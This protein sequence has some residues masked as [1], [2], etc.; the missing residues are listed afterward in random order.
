VRALA[1]PRTPRSRARSATSSTQTALAHHLGSALPL[2]PAADV[3]RLR[4]AGRLP[5]AGAHALDAALPPPVLYYNFAVG[6][7]ADLVW[8]VSLLDYATAR[9]LPEGEV[10]K[11]VRICLREVDARGLEAEGIYRVRGLSAVGGEVG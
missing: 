8:G 7:C 3:E 5:G 10:P 4:S 1:A 11:I 9:A 6:E 2:A